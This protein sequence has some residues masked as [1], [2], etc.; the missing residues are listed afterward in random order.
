[1]ASPLYFWRR[2]K[3]YW[4]RRGIYVHMFFAMVLS[5]TITFNSTWKKTV[6]SKKKMNKTIHTIVTITGNKSKNI[7]VPRYKEK[8]ERFFWLPFSWNV[9]RME[10]QQCCCLSAYWMNGSQCLDHQSNSNQIDFYCVWWLLTPRY[11]RQ[12]RWGGPGITWEY[13]I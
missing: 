11:C 9:T 6:W 12:N 4:L 7:I 10:D 1:M 13:K 3:P 5:R 2:L 8:L